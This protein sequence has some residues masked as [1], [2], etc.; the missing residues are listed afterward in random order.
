V[1]LSPTRPQQLAGIRIAARLAGYGYEGG[2]M[3]GL[4]TGGHFGESALRSLP[5]QAH[6]EFDVDPVHWSP[7]SVTDAPFARKVIDDSVLDFD[8]G[9]GGNLLDIVTEV[10]GTTGAFQSVGAGIRYGEAFGG[11]SRVVDLSVLGNETLDWHGDT[12]VAPKPLSGLGTKSTF[13]IA[14]VL[15]QSQDNYYN[16]FVFGDGDGLSSQGTSSNSGN[17]PPGVPDPGDVVKEYQEEQSTQD[18]RVGDAEEELEEQ[19]EAEE[20]G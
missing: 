5:A 12:L 9:R 2:V 17:A 11:A 19:Q 14:W 13:G 20:G 8:R 4:G 15:A 18:E 7:G 3:V 1:G 10:I 6:P 16:L